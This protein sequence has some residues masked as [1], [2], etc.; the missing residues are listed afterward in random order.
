MR[1]LGSSTHPVA[2]LAIARIVSAQ[3]YNTYLSCREL[4]QYECHFMSLRSTTCDISR[5]KGRQY[6]HWYVTALSI[7]KTITDHCIEPELHAASRTSRWKLVIPPQSRPT[8]AREG[9]HIPLATGR[10]PLL[11]GGSTQDST[12]VRVRFELP[13]KQ[14]MIQASGSCVSQSTPAE[15]VTAPSSPPTASRCSDLDFLDFQTNWRISSPTLSSETSGH[16]PRHVSDAVSALWP[17]NGLRLRRPRKARRHLYTDVVDATTNQG[18]MSS[19]R[20]K[21]QPP[22][23]SLHPRGEGKPAHET[24]NPYASQWKRKRLGRAQRKIASNL[25]RVW[26]IASGQ[27]AHHECPQK[28]PLQFYDSWRCSSYSPS[29]V[30]ERNAFFAPFTN[31]REFPSCILVLL[32]DY[33]ENWYGEWRP[34]LLRFWKNIQFWI[35]EIGSYLLLVPVLVPWEA[36]AIVAIL[37]E[38]LW[39]VGRGMSKDRVLVKLRDRTE[40][41]ATGGVV[42]V[43][44]GTCM[45]FTGGQAR[46]HWQR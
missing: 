39:N 27:G 44:V 36:C 15:F 38:R 6:T 18:D 9:Q 7:G 11:H 43:L 4:F 30:V 46:R 14:E 2:V 28:R 32:S 31:S 20:S 24:V 19:P 29:T 25:R 5:S 21:G 10:G 23:Q 12:P 13:K 35:I 41:V 3:V 42:R 26:R 17:S 34:L 33:Q 1:I 40:W 37:L 16:G 8:C 45:A 22:L